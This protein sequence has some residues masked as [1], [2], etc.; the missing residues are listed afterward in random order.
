MSESAFDWLSAAEL[1][2]FTRVRRFPL[3]VVEAMLNR[4]EAMQPHLNALVS[5]DKDVA[6]AAAK[7]S[8]ARWQKGEPCRPSTVFQRRFKDTPTSR[9]GRPATVRTP[10]MRLGARQRCR[11]RQVPCS[12]HDHFRQVDDAEFGWKAL[13][14]SPLQ[15][16][17]RNPWNLA[18]HRVDH[19][20]APRR[21]RRRGSI[22]QPRQR[23][24]RLDPHS[25]QSH[26][27]GRLKPSYGRIPQCIPPMPVRRRDQ[28]GP[29]WRDPSSTRRWR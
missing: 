14:D 2:N 23:W 5:I 6:Q 21:S 22:L 9:D 3:E 15:G 29:C 19:R 25:G 11:D 13:T 24:R 7:A 16:T 26:R 1:S 10:R 20:A 28:P 4:A 18:T 8:E 12:G 17:T 27:P